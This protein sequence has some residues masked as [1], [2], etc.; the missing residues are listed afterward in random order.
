MNNKLSAF[1]TR[2]IKPALGVLGAAGLASCANFQGSIAPHVSLEDIVDNVQC[3]LQAA[4]RKYQP[5][6][7]GLDHWAASFTITMKREDRAGVS[8]KFDFLEADKFGLGA[9]AEVSTDTI[10]SMTSKRTLVLEDLK[11]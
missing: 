1:W 3:E 4:Y 5:R 10:R 7:K 11:K 6:Y 2:I 9:T 8:P